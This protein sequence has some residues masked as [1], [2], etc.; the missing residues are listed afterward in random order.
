MKKKSENLR[1]KLRTGDVVS[2]KSFEEIGSA[3]GDDGT[4]EG[5]PF[6]PEM[7]KYCGGTFR[8]LRSVKKLIFE[9]ANRGLRGIRN[10]VLLDGVNCKEANCDANAHFLCPRNCYLLWRK[11]W[12]NK[13]S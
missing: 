11:I 1:L 6:Q 13:I 5:L 12:L 9:N 7:A 8:V 4:I 2:I 10:T 3:V